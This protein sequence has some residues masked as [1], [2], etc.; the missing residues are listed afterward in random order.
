MNIPER[1]TFITQNNNE[2]NYYFED[3]SVKIPSEQYPLN[4][5]AEF[6]VSENTEYIENQKYL[7]IIDTVKVQLGRCYTNAAE[8]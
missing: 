6:F 5:L 7:D 1:F 8:I 2:F 3:S 4:Q